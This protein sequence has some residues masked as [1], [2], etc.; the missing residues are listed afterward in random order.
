MKKS[1]VL[2]LLLVCVM[3]VV[4]QPVFAAE[5][6]A[7]SG[8]V[9]V[10]NKLCP[11]SGE[12]VS[13]TSFVEYQGKRYGLCCSGCDKMFLAEPEKYLAKMNAQEAAL[14][15]KSVSTQEPMRETEH[16]HHEM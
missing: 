5:E 1:V 14:V 12:P 8:I 13:G 9:D 7:Q 10:G 6:K 16:S 3:S 2:A 15:Q 4:A 11:I